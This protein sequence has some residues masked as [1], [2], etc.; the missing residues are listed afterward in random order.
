M[1]KMNQKAH[2]VATTGQTEID[3]K[4]GGG[5]PMG[6]LTLVEGQSDSGK[7]VL[8]QQ[9]CFGSLQAELGVAYYTSENTVKSLVT[10][11]ISLNMD[12]TD[13]FLID[14]LRI[15]PLA[16]PAKT[17]DA[18]AIFTRLLGHMQSLPKKFKL[19]IIDSLT[20]V[21]SHSN[22]TSVI[23]F[24]TACKQYCDEDRIL[25]IVAHTS[26]F[27]ERMFI[28]VRSLCDAHFSL[29][30]EVVGERLIKVMEVSKVRNAEL[31]SGNIVSF[32]VEAGLGIR[33]IPV[34]KAKA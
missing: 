30:V 29:R 15:Y 3:K 28:R 33:I 22:E 4:L 8:S 27:D 7:S 34:S 24:F 1:L 11:M 25:L 2:V 6:S 23:D 5:I 20:N 16:L 14:Q 10:Q 19:V 26:A 17:N 18:D 31:N 12:V 9:I 21:V 32:D 13:Y